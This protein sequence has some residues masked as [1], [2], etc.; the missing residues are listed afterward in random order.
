V[1]VS[2]ETCNE[3]T[4][5]NRVNM[6]KILV[7]VVFLFLVAVTDAFAQTDSVRVFESSNNFVEIKNAFQRRLQSASLEFK[8][9]FHIQNS[10]NYE[11]GRKRKYFIFEA[12]EGDIYFLFLV[13]KK[14][15]KTI[16]FIFINEEIEEATQCSDI[17]INKAL[18]LYPDL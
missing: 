11:D 9:F 17:E 12:Y 8:Y 2:R 15:S 10:F 1:R 18:A 7:A 14:D 6:K 13:N 5:R 4:T 16:G 3:G